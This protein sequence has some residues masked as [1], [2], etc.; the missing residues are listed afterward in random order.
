M[1]VSGLTINE[2]TVILN[3]KYGDF[4][5][6]PDVEISIEKYRPIVISIDGEVEDPGIYTLNNNSES[7][8]CLLYTS[9][10]ADES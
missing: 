8:L 3:K 2:L 7:N 1:F 6:D 5:F 10:A 4:I 9:D